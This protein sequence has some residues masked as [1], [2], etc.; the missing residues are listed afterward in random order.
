MNSYKL[1]Q[2]KMTEIEKSK[3]KKSSPD[4]EN[5]S[6][7]KTTSETRSD[8]N[9]EKDR[10]LTKASSTRRSEAEKDDVVI[11]TSTKPQDPNVPDHT[12]GDYYCRICDSHMNSDGMWEAHI[13]GKR[14]LKNLKKTTPETKYD[15]LDE[16][17]SILYEIRNV[18]D[19]VVGLSYIQEIR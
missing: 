15:D 6:T 4:S 9:F 2:Q 14:H 7:K 17:S 19:A 11:V 16:E 3:R 18:K 12:Y 5:S 10:N 8:R 1:L 13:T